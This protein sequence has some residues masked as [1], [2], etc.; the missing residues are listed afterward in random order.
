MSSNLC[1]QSQAH[2]LYSLYLHYDA[3]HA[4]KHED[5]EVTVPSALLSR[6][7]TP[8]PSFFYAL[9]KIRSNDGPDR[10]RSTSSGMALIALPAAVLT[11]LKKK[12]SERQ[13]AFLQRNDP[14]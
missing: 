14:Q 12:E 8:H 9:M 1:Q 2:R 7:D 4:A 13:R 6:F 3:S 11:T 5:P 10:A